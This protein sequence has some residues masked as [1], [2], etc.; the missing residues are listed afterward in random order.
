MAMSHSRMP[1][2]GDK[3]HRCNIL[4]QCRDDVVTVVTIELIKRSFH[5]LTA[6]IVLKLRNKESK[7]QIFNVR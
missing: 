3:F 5:T 7:V 4:L 2:L 1:L 6:Q